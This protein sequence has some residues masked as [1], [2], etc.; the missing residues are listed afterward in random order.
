MNLRD[1][2]YVLIEGGAW[3][4][5]DGFAVRIDLTDQM[6]VVQIFDSKAMDALREDVNAARMASAHAYTS[7]LCKPDAV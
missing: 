7:D 5:V 3:F 6:V 4:E 1:D 2:D